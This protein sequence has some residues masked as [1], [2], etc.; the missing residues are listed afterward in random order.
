MKDS[1]ILLLLFALYSTVFF[2]SLEGGTMKCTGLEAVGTT[3]TFYDDD[4]VLPEK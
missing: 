3:T 2:A 1:F 4:E